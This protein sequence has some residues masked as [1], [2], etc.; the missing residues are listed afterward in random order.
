ML[1]GIGC[2]VGAAES[3]LCTNYLQGGNSIRFSSAGL[4]TCPTY[5]LPNQSV[6]QHLLVI[7]NRRTLKF[8]YS[9][10]HFEFRT[11]LPQDAGSGG[12]CIRPTTVQLRPDIQGQRW[13]RARH[14][15]KSAEATEEEI[16]AGSF[17]GREV[18]RLGFQHSNGASGSGG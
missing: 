18:V 1:T 8:V 2:A 16:T 5:S 13:R 10:W 12:V 9:E 4:S 3:T 17:I 15:A 7:Q 14:A 11:W 6:S